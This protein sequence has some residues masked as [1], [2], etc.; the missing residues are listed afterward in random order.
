MP[1]ALP[2][3]SSIQAN[4]EDFTRQLI[5]IRL[6]DE[7]MEVRMRG[8]KAAQMGSRL[9]TIRAQTSDGGQLS[10]R[11]S[12]NSTHLQVGDADKSSELL[13][14]CLE[15]SY[16]PPTAPILWSALLGSV[17]ELPGPGNLAIRRQ[18]VN[19]I[20]TSSGHL[21]LQRSGLVSYF[22]TTKVRAKAGNVWL[23][24]DGQANESTLQLL[25]VDC[26]L[27][28]VLLNI[29]IRPSIFYGL[30]AEGRTVATRT[31]LD[32][33]AAREVRFGLDSLVP[34]RYNQIIDNQ[35]QV[36]AVPF[37]ERL[38]EYYIQHETANP[39]SYSLSRYAH[40]LT[41][42][43]VD[44][45]YQLVG[46][47][48]AVLVK[49]F[50]K[51]LGTSHSVQLAEQADRLL[52]ERLLSSWEVRSKADHASLAGYAELLSLQAERALLTSLDPEAGP[53]VAE[54]R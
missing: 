14:R 42:F 47:A 17:N 46:G 41:Q 10:G 44:T 35:I 22:I 31:I 45:Q 53:L 1:F 18:T 26:Q 54:A 27:F 49:E 25:Q 34:I 2:P 29:P 11:I 24:F 7:A 36:W 51:R 3:V 23:C 32:E 38:H 19:Q 20:N 4:D 30:N 40:T 52:A 21:R 50:I 28:R 15:W 43:D 16:T 9:R 8:R 12:A 37:Y 13:L 33:Q 5:S 6:V 48:V 39:I